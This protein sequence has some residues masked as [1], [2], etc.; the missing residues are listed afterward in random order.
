MKNYYTK[1]LLPILLAISLLIPNLVFSV[2]ADE[3]DTKLT[4][5]QFEK[6]GPVIVCK[7]TYA[8][9]L[10]YQSVKPWIQ[11]EKTGA[12][13]F[14]KLI[15]TNTDSPD[16]LTKAE[17][18]I[19]D[20]K[21]CWHGSGKKIFDAYKQIYIQ[22]LAKNHYRLS[23]FKNQSKNTTP[24]NYNLIFQELKV[25]IGKLTN[26]SSNEV[27]PGTSVNGETQNGKP[28]EVETDSVGHNGQGTNIEDGNGSTINTDSIQSLNAHILKKDKEIKDLKSRII[29]LGGSIEKTSILK[30]I[31]SFWYLFVIA[32]L[33]LII[34]FL[35]K[36]KLAITKKEQFHLDNIKQLEKRNRGLLNNQNAAATVEQLMRELQA[37]KDRN[38]RLDQENK[39]LRDDLDNAKLNKQYPTNQNR[40]STEA[41]NTPSPDYSINTQN[42]YTHQQQ[43]QTAAP[44]SLKQAFLPFP[45][46]DIKIN[47]ADQT[48]SATKDTFFRID[49]E[50]NGRKARISIY[51]NK[52]LLQM[53]FNS[54]EAI[55]KP[56]CKY[57]REPRSGQ[58]N[59]KTINPGIAELQ[60]GDWRVTD[61]IQVEFS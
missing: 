44:S 20:S 47:A 2:P 24:T 13:N 9:M 30:K 60:G 39:M 43:N 48:D 50:S 35:I 55:I 1:S 51:P 28:V 31:L 6:I 17:D 8:Y 41:I 18:F 3:I 4:K 26:T 10:D 40:R 34:I 42:Q 58:Y 46:E 32:A 25:E 19:K 45:Y 52:D 14:S 54:F 12:K 21:N 33:I 27:A 53:A 36:S 11:C 16:L 61:K 22:E 29:S 7:L 15:D 59:I 49:I 5:E 23:Q 37:L 56:V 38:N 57:N